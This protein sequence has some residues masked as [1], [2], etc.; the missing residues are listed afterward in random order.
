MMYVIE[1]FYSQPFITANNINCVF[2]IML[3]TK[4]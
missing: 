2:I 3:E 4:H 1:L